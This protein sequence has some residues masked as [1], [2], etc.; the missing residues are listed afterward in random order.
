MDEV[1]AYRA[2]PGLLCGLHALHRTKTAHLGFDWAS[3][4]EIRL[5]E[6]WAWRREVDG[7]RASNDQGIP[8]REQRWAQEE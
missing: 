6:F 8:L 3:Y 2:I 5:A 1:D 7:S 4:A